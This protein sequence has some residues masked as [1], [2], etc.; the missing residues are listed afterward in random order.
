[1]NR[2]SLGPKGGLFITE[3]KRLIREA[4]RPVIGVFARTKFCGRNPKKLGPC[5]AW[6]LAL[7]DLETAIGRGRRRKSP[8]VEAQ[9][10]R[11]A[12]RPGRSAKPRAPRRARAF[13]R[14]LARGCQ[15]AAVVEPESIRLA[16]CGCGEAL[17]RIGEDRTERLDYIPARLFRSFVR[18]PPICLAPRGATGVV[19]AKAPAASWLQ[20]AAGRPRRLLAQI[21]GVQAFRAHALQTAGPWSWPGMGLPSDR[22]GAATGGQN[23]KPDR[24]VVDHMGQA[25]L[26]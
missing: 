3:L 16:R 20:R 7:E 12:T 5:A 26:S 17:V 4:L 10:S 25:L 14:K 2:L 19:Q 9:G 24:P 18:A 11:P 21:S 6:K 1:M 22:S 8:H 15:S 23:R 13:A